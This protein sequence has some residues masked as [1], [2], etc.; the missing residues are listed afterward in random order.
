MKKSAIM[1][2]TNNVLAHKI[3]HTYNRRSEN[4]P[5]TKSKCI[6]SATQIIIEFKICYK[7][8]LTDNMPQE[9]PWHKHNLYA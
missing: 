1:C 6:K 3:C 7:I 2:A 8:L 4:L 9:I 5:Q